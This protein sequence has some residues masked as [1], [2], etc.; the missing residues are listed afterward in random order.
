MLSHVL[1]T[2]TFEYS[3]QRVNPKLSLAYWD[4]TIET[5]SS[6]ADQASAVDQDGHDV[7]PIKTPVFQESWYGETDPATHMVNICVDWLRGVG[8]K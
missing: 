7:F 6:S 1:M 3:L 2:N 8:G 5:S 4:F